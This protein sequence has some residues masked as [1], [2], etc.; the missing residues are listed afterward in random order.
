[1]T[2]AVPRVVREGLLEEVIFEP[3]FKNEA[4][5]R[6][7]GGRVPQAKETGRSQAWE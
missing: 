5:M 7:S 4:V 6:R 1:M 3:R 2:A